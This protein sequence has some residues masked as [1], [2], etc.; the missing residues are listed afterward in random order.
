MNLPEKIEGRI[1]GEIMKV[2]DLIKELKKMPQ[3]LDVGIS[4]HDNYEYEVAGW[5]GFVEHYKFSK[6]L[7]NELSEQEYGSSCSMACYK[8]NGKEWVTIHC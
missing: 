8:A 2:K 6:K 4:L 7:Y 1:I 3:N 5:A